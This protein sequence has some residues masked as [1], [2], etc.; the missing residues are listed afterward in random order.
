VSELGQRLGE[1]A[2]TPALLLWGMQDFV[3]DHTCLREF[4]RAWPQAR[5]VEYAEAG[6]YVLED[7]R[8]E[9]L[10]EVAAFL[11]AHPVAT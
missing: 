6:H 3:F 8:A 7:A 9:V 5:A 2:H 11:Q 4:R 10:A 1:F